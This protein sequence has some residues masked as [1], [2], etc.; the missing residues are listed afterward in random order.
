[1]GLSYRPA[2]RPGLEIGASYYLDTVPRP[3]LHSVA[4]RIAA[5]YLAYRTTSVEIFAEWLRLTHRADARYSNDAGYV[6]AS[7]AWGKLRPYYRYDRLAID[8][9]TPFIGPSG[10]YRAHIVGVRIDP[11]ESAGIKAQY[12]RTDDRT[13]HG[14]DSVRTE[15]VFVF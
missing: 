12:E 4:H 13:Q 10:S 15:L 14:V 1:V 5:G 6:Q 11:A 8:A 3:S 7:R 9:R 2:R